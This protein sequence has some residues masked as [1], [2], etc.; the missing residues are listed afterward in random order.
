M[1]LQ[2]FKIIE[3]RKRQKWVCLNAVIYLFFSITF[4]VTL[5]RCL[6]FVTYI[7]T[8]RNIHHFCYS[9][10]NN[11]ICIYLHLNGV[12]YCFKFVSTHAGFVNQMSKLFQ[13]SV[14]TVSIL[15]LQRG[16]VR[17]VFK[18]TMTHHSKLYLLT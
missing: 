11:F 17:R 4:C 3:Q 14:V 1:K 9:T 10:V 7:L 18:P 6:V 2:G 5:S 13:V 15:S 12:Y 8:S 16:H